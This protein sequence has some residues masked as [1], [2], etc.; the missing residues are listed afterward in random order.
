M[1]PTDPSRPPIPTM[2]WP[3][4][5]SSRPGSAWLQQL[6]GRRYR[7]RP[8]LAAARRGL[9]P[10]AVVYDLGGGTGYAMGIFATLGA[11]R[12]PPTCVLLEP[13]RK[14]LDR[15]RRR[16]APAGAAPVHLL[17]GDAA[18]VPFPDSSADLVLS[19][20]VLC[21]MAPAAV[22]RAIQ[23][24][25]RVL[26]PTGR[27][28]FAVPRRHI[29][30]H[31]LRLRAAGFEVVA[32]FGRTRLLLSKGLSA[33]PASSSGAPVPLAGRSVSEGDRVAG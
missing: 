30:P 25:D 3:A 4:A 2:R 20:G 17:R 7:L 16:F 24:I 29:A 18:S 12:D 31:E 1:T 8:L 27:L 21:C 28:A 15:A 19:I 14:M 13:Q 6:P 9:P 11:D 10:S 22:P 5:W 26:R 32:R 23:E 33:G